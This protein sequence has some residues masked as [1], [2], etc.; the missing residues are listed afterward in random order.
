MMK[1]RLF[2]LLNLLLVGWAGAQV[3]PSMR[4]QLMLTGRIVDTAGLGVVGAQVMVWDTAA[5]PFV[6]GFTS[7]TNNGF[8]SLRVL[9]RASG[10]LRMRVTDCSGQVYLDSVVYNGSNA[11]TRNFTV[12]CRIRIPNPPPPPPLRPCNAA[13]SFRPD[14]GLAVRFAPAVVDT[15]WTYR[16]SFGDGN[17]STQVSP[18]HT[19]ASGGMYTVRLVVTRLA[20][21]A[22]AACSDTE[23]RVVN[24]P[25]PPRP[26]ISNP[27][28]IPCNPRFGARIDTTLTVQFRSVMQDTMAQYSWNFGNGATSNGRNPSHTYSA[29][30]SYVVVLAVS[31]PGTT[32]GTSCTDT[33]WLRISVPGYRRPRIITN[34]RPVPPPSPCQARYLVTT[35]TQ[36]LGYMFSVRPAMARMTYAWSFGDGTTAT[37]PTVRHTYA[38]AASYTVCLTVTDTAGACTSTRC[39]TLVASSLRSSGGGI[40]APRQASTATSSSIPQQ[41]LE[42]YPN[43][44]R[45]TLHLVLGA[46]QGPAVLRIMDLTGRVILTQPF[47]L[48]SA[49]QR[50]SIAVQDWPLGTYVLTLDREGKREYRRFVKQ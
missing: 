22:G 21:S 31:R 15:L 45:E 7:T 19:Y 36:P 1:I 12:Q 11:F 39:D 23:S 35:D 40:G 30:G 48:G 29:A 5:Q 49:T 13:F 8:Y 46:G 33:A 6:F 37:G 43:P 47:K 32:T 38:S 9:G 18:A 41:S 4:S 2:L 42:L 24:V 50:E 34:P 25:M 17:L 10:T 28:S 20:T 27:W 16:W 3:S 26:P 14:T 44:V